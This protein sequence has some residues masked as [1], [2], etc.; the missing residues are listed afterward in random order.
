VIAF[1]NFLFTTYLSLLSFIP[2]D[3]EDG[4]AKHRLKFDDERK[5]GTIPAR[6][7]LLYLKACGIPT[8]VVFF[9][10]TFMWQAL[11]VYTDVWLRDWTDSEASLDDGAVDV[12][13]TL[14]SLYYILRRSFSGKFLNCV[15]Q[16]LKT[17]SS[18]FIQI[19]S[20]LK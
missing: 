6:I 9:M 11:R 7:Y 2:I 10:S 3:L 8:L 14:K 19:S 16:I 18:G 4:S 17:I 5:Y 15:T 1:N 12:C 20:L 13:R